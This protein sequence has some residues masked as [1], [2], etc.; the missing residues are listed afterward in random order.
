SIQS[1]FLAQILEKVLLPPALEHPV[2]QQGGPEVT[3]RS[4]N[5]SL[6]PVVHQAGDLAQP[7]FAFE[8]THLLIRQDV[9]DAAALLP[10]GVWAKTSFWN[11][12]VTALAIGQQVEPGRQDRL[13]ELGTVAAA[14]ED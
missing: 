8:Q 6:M 4:Q 12:R 13:K 3:T 7:Q 11:P 9:G 1:V 10:G 14:I 5:G 2:G